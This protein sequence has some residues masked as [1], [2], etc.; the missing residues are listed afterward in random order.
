MTSGQLLFWFLSFFVAGVFTGWRMRGEFQPSL[1][2]IKKRKAEKAELEKIK[3]H[4]F[5]KLEPP[6]RWEKYQ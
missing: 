1:E 2:A 6:K 3:E 4:E 5:E